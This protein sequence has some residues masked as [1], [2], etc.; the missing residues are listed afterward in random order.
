MVGTDASAAEERRVVTVLFADVVGF[1]SLA[2]HRDPEQVKRMV[3]DAF[4]L[5]VADVESYGG[6]V[7]KVLGDAIVALFG[8]PVAHEDDADRAVRAA[9]AMQRT[10]SGFRDEHPADDLRMRIGINTGEVLVGTVAGSDYTAMGD[11]VNTASRLQEAAVSDSI[12]V[13]GATRALCSPTVRFRVVDEVRLRGRIG[14]TDVWE[15]VAID[16]AN[17]TQRWDSDAPFVGR[18]AELAILRA[19]TNTVESGRAAIVAVSGEAGIGKSRL[20]GEAIG[21]LTA[22]HPDALLLSGAC[23]PYGETNVWWPVAGSVLHRLG[24]DRSYSGGDVRQRVVKRLSPFEELQPGTARF[25]RFVEFVLHVLGQPSALDALGPVAIRDAVIDGMA[26]ALRRRAERTP[27]V[28]WV[29]DV[30]WAAPVLLELLEALARQLAGLPLLIATTMRDDSETVESWPPAADPAVTLHLTLEALPEDDAAELVQRVAGRDLSGPV[31][32]AISTRSGGNPLFLIELAK[33]AAAVSGDDHDQVELPGT[34]RALIAAQLDRLSPTQREIIDNAAI[35]GNEGRVSSLRRFAQSLGQV[36]EHEEFAALCEAGLLVRDARRWRFRS[37]VLREVAY[38][39]LTKQVR[40]ERHAAVAEYLWAFEPH[41]I[42]RRAH[43]MASAAEIVLELG[44]LAGVPDDACEKAVEWLAESARNWQLQGAARRGLEVVERA[45]RL[46]VEAEPAERRSIDLLRVDLLFDAHRYREARDAIAELRPV[47][48]AAG[49]RVIAAETARIL[50][51]IEQMEGDLIGARRELT[52]AVAEFRALDDDVHLAEALRARGFAE[53]FGG[54]LADAERFLHESEELYATTVDDPRGAAWVQQNL[55]WV[56]FLGGD[57]ELSERRLRGAIDAFAELSDRGGESWAKGLLAYVYHFN[58]RDDDALALAAEAF[59]DARQWGDTWGGSM[60]LNLQASVYLWR[61]EVGRSHDLAEK[62]LA[63]FRRIEDRFGQIQALGNV[64]RSSVALGRIAE[65]DRAVEEVLVLSDNFGEMAFPGISAAGTAMHLGRGREV[66]RQAREAIGRLD[67]TG[68]N[69]DEGRVVVAFGEL[70]T[71][72]PEQALAVLVDADVESL[73]FALAA[74]A[75]ASAM[76]GDRAQA[77]ADAD[78][79]IAFGELSYWDR[80]IALAAG[81]AAAPADERETRRNQLI[82]FVAP[83]EDV[84]VAAY[85]GRL[86][87]HDGVTLRTDGDASADGPTSR[88]IDIGGW[89]VV[90]D[91]LAGVP[92]SAVD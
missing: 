68:A 76:I 58:R 42:D 71:G 20:V 44:P 75:T 61:G 23:A 24:F 83:L 84:V 48:D 12:F 6:V 15:A 38:Q 17:P 53:V 26:S 60:M 88:S 63:G 29:D 36:Y 32:A 49:D 50:G 8:A 56:S 28:I 73:P 74:R 43:H 31:L 25:D 19:V 3:D 14:T 52:T 65:A 33:L 70:L 90:A 89:A 54:S 9:M 13:G 47:A 41:A 62:A 79:V 5:L 1:T 27:V 55:A 80:A 46:A 35:I 2:E 34:L 87:G 82:E 39:T 72:D 7:D 21:A 30:Q 40:A 57:H 11:V 59:S 10:L 16:E 86:L 37:D 66:V 77:V 51:T 4:E 78:A 81:Y 67:T 22:H 92:A 45:L 18:E 69:V 91:R 85:V 64:T